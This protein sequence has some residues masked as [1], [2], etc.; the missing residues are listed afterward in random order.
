MDK[1]KGSDF[2]QRPGLSAVLI[3]WVSVARYCRW[4]KIESRWYI[5]KLGYVR[6]VGT[7]AEWRYVD[8]DMF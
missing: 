1:L 8:E 7:A 3:V 6:S 2:A 5:P 4:V